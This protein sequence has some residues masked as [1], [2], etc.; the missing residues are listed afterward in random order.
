MSD[1]KLIEKYLDNLSPSEYS[2][3]KKRE[4]KL[5]NK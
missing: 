5:I 1:L 3:E 2:N 4:E